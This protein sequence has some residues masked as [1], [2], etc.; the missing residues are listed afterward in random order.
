[1]PRRLEEAE[2]LGEPLLNTREAASVLRLSS[3]FL[4]KA[5]MRGD[6]PAFL[7][8]GTAVRYR[9][10]ALHDWM[11]SRARLSTSER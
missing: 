4:A 11:R 2:P 9:L 10:S 7:R 1:M 8:F 5:R 3:S 6:G